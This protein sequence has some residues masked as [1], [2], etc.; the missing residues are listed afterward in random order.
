MDLNIFNQK[1][2]IEQLHKAYIKRDLSPVEV[3]KHLLKRIE[4]LNPKNKSFIT[5]SPE[6]A[7]T[8]A[9]LSEKRYFNNMS[10]SRLDGIPLSYKDSINTKG[11]KTTNGSIFEG[12]YVPSYNADIVNQLNQLGTV[13]LGKNN[14]H[15]YSY[16]SS[17]NNPHYG[18][19]RNPWN[20]NFSPGGSSG[21]SASAVASG[22][23]VFSIGTDTAGSIREPAATCGI[24]GLKPTY[25]LIS[26]KG[27]TNASWTKGHVGP[28]TSTVKDLDIFMQEILQDRYKTFI[29]KDLR[30]IRIGVPTIHF[31]EELDS[32]IEKKFNKS[33]NLLKKLGAN[34]IEIELPT[35]FCKSMEYSLKLSQGEGSIV[36][37][38][39]IESSLNKLGDYVRSAFSSFNEA[40]AKEYLESLQKRQWYKNQID[41]VFCNVDL[42]LTPTSPALHGPI[43]TDLAIVNGREHDSFIWMIR[44][45]HVFNM[46]GHPAISIPVGLANNIH[47]VGIQFIAPYNK[48]NLLIAMAYEYEKRFLDNFYKKR[49]KICYTEAD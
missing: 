39:I 14:L 46:T 4:K 30:G 25:N 9:K 7:L 48:D 35:E 41:K 49:Q 21:G 6:I 23:S 12:N 17:S 33:C 45:T 16:G 43:G 32:T 1:F 37:K 13:T 24:I 26:T 27:V 5:I 44:N 42:I 22:M 31:T 10:L 3:V 2:T 34:L 28:L 11:I 15:E 29:K 36:F 18:A 38:D 8:Q 20:H 47:P 40:T 19:V